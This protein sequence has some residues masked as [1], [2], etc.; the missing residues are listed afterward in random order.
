MRMKGNKLGFTLWE[1]IRWRLRMLWWDITGKD[2][3]VA[4]PYPFEDDGITPK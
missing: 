4:M 3:G 1:R 2:D